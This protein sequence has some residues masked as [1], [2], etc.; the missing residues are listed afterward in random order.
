LPDPHIALA[1]LRL[2]EEASS[3][4]LATFAAERSA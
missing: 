1:S 3:A 2:A 4:I